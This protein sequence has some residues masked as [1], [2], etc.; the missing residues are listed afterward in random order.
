MDILED[1]IVPYN[2]QIMGFARERMDTRGY[3]DLRTRLG[4]K[5]DSEER[6]VRYLLLEANTSYNALLRRPC[7]NDF[8][9]IVSTPHLTMK[10]P[11][12][13]GTICTVRADQKMTTE[14][15][16]ANLKMYPQV[17]RRKTNQS[18]LAMAD[19]VPRTNTNN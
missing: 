7:L 18:K 5:R 10:Y 3:V 19:L 6:R 15:Y 12:N 16:A 11:S 2:E 14:C 8:G 9:A 1:L 13:K 4:T 17:N